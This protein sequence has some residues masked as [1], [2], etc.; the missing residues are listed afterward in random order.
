[1]ATLL[2]SQ[3]RAEF[4]VQLPLRSIFEAPTVTE[5]AARTELAILE[6][7][8]EDELARLLSEVENLSEEEARNLIQDRPQSPTA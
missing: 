1:M 2:I 7:Q 3:A 5:L 8:E 4:H 6:S